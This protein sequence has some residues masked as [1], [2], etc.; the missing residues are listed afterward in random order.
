MRCDLGSV[1]NPHDPPCVRCRRESK[2]C[3]F[4]ATRRKRK[5][6]D[7]DDENDDAYVIRNGRKQHHLALD[8]SPPPPTNKHA[9]RDAPLTPG[10][11]T[12]TTQPLRRP[13]NEGAD[14]RKSK[15]PGLPDIGDGE[16]NAQ[17]ENLEAQSVMRQEVY[18]PHDALDLLYKA[19]TNKSVLCRRNQNCQAADHGCSPH[20]DMLHRRQESIS[21]TILPSPATI[22]S[23]KTPTDS[24]LNAPLPR[25]R[26]KSRS[27]DPI[28]PRL[29]P[30]PQEDSRDK[31][32]R[33]LDFQSDPGYDDAIKAWSRFRFV[34][35]G[36]FTSHEAIKYI[37]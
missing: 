12:G 30:G 34:R 8:I 4:S 18:G 37:A 19:A 32:E 29:M 33:M 5:H 13:N 22:T 2:E 31:I 25:G 9:Y 23:T 16:P 24:M 3:Y 17:M 10:G 26:L 1:D 20:E 35:A 14:G 7:D 21:T 28:D 6:D 15:R 27:A 36:W 11:S